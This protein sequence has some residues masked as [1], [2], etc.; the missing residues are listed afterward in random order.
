MKASP[1]LSSSSSSFSAIGHLFIMIILIVLLIFVTS[2]TSTA[3][4]DASPTTSLPQLQ[5]H[6]CDALTHETSRSLCI[7]LHRVYQHRLPV[8]V[9]P[10][11]LTHNEIDPRY[12]VEK[13]LVP[14]GPNPLHN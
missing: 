7:H 3:V 4:P 6:P 11:L 2:S 1:S 9:L 10:P 14:S 8:H 12:G 5:L 13:R